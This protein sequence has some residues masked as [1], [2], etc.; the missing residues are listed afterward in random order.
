MPA[1]GGYSFADVC[2]KVLALAIER[3]EARVRGTLGRGDLPR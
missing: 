1:A 3:H 2:E